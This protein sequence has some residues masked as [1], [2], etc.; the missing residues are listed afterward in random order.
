MCT[1][2]KWGKRVKGYASDI[3]VDLRTNTHTT[4]V[5]SFQET[6]VVG[7]N[8]T[9]M[10]YITSAFLVSV[11]HIR[12]LIFFKIKSKTWEKAEEKGPWGHLSTTNVWTSRSVCVVKKRI[13]FSDAHENMNIHSKRYC[14]YGNFRER[15]IFAKL[16]EIRSFVKIKASRDCVITLSFTDVG[17]TVANLIVTNT[18]FNAFAKIKFPRK[19]PDLQ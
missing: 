3:H 2:L 8:C 14:K 5:R 17:K 18:S 9:P 6:P 19:F 11:E 15:F 16:R 7:C 12:L 13:S 1:R 4:H 10:V